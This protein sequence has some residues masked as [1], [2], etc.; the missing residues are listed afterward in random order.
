MKTKLPTTRGIA[1][2]TIIRQ[3]N[4]EYDIIQFCDASGNVKLEILKN[5]ETNEVFDRYLEKP[6]NC[7]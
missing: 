4:D 2:T 6:H 7:K 1:Y 3:L 5:K